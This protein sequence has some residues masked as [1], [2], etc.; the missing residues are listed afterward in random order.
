MHSTFKRKS[1]AILNFLHINYRP[2]NGLMPNTLLRA[3]SALRTLSMRKG[4]LFTLVGNEVPDYFY[5]IQGRVQINKNEQYTTIDA[6]DDLGSLHFFPAQFKTMEVEA[7]S[8]CTLVQADSELLSELLNWNEMALKS[9]L[10]D[11]KETEACLD[12]MRKSKA[13]R[14]LPVEAMDEVFHRLER[15]EVRKDQ[16]VITQGDKGEAFYLI[17]S[18]RVEVWR[19]DIYDDEQKL[20]ATL[21]N[22]D[23]FGEESLLLRGTCNATVR[24]LEDGVLFRLNE[25]DFHEL[26]ATPLLNHVSPCV[27][28]SMLQNGYRLL[29]VRYEEEYDDSHVPGAILIP[30]P[31]LRSRFDEIDPTQKYLL[32]CAGGKRATVGALLLRQQHVKE[33][34][35]IEGGMHDWPYE[36][37]SNY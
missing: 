26:V 34:H 7:L 2:F 25:H 23:A 36:A 29:D 37:I 17:V 10:F 32:I 16:D 22:G 28:N 33:V 21:S 6:I 12:S 19:Q 3:D 20:V 27:A 13:F 14:K 4:E 8:D 9:G 15:V 31:E 5:V 35:I 30:L 18:G 24:M 1:D 11:T